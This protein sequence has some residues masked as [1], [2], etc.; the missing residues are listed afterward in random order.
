[1]SKIIIFSG[2]DKTG[3]DTLISSFNRITN[4]K[5]S[6]INRSLP[7]NFAYDRLYERG[8]VLKWLK[9]DK[10]LD[11]DVFVIIYLYSD[12]KTLKQRFKKTNER[13]IKLEKDYKKLMNYYNV[14]FL[15]THLKFMKLNTSKHSIDE[16]LRRIIK[17]IES[18]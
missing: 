1:M 10:K 8:D 12:V 16:C 11:K 15:N 4:F 5:H 7:D 18:K 6:C 2:I 9:L 17:F 14:Y 13:D 3:K